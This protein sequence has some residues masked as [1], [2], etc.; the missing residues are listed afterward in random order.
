M[1]HNQR[2]PNQ[3]TIL[4]LCERI[5]V[6][7]GD[8]VTLFFTKNRVWANSVYCKRCEV[9]LTIMNVLSENVSKI[10]GYTSANTITTTF[11]IAS[12]PNIRIYMYILLGFSKSPCPIF[13]TL[14]FE[15][16]QNCFKWR[17][18]LKLSTVSLSVIHNSICG[19]LFTKS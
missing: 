12:E 17:K 11:T 16:Y 3:A 19:L 1:L 14:C 15:A 7:C 10:G 13:D 18:A 4:V 5:F 8:R 2:I 6:D 9:L